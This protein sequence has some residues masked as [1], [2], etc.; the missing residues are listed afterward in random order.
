[1][2]RRSTP[3]IGVAFATLLSLLYAVP[4]LA[5]PLDKSKHILLLHSYHY[6]TPW[7]H[8]VKKGVQQIL[9]PAVDKSE[10][11]LRFSTKY[12]DTMH[13]P[14]SKYP[15]RL[16]R[17]LRG[18]DS[19]A[20]PDVIITAD[21]TALEILLEHHSE[22]A[23]DSQIVF[24]GYSDLT[25]KGADE[26]Q[27]ITGVV[28]PP[29][30]RETLE[31]ILTLL[32][33]TRKIL[34]I[35]D[36]SEMGETL[37]RH[38]R[39]QTKDLP[40][41]GMI[42]EY[43][44]YTF[45]M[46]DEKLK[47]LPEHTIVLLLSSVQ[48]C[49]N[50]MR[51]HS[52]ALRRIQAATSRPIFSILKFY[53]DK[54]IVGGKVMEGTAQGIMAAEVALRLAE[55][56]QTAVDIPVIT[57][58]ENRFVFD[59]KQLAQ[60]HISLKKVPKGSTILHTPPSFLARNKVVIFSILGTLA[61][62]L[63]T[64]YRESRH[65]LKR[66]AVENSLTSAENRYRE[67]MDSTH[68]IILHIDLAGT[69]KFIND[70]G[71]S[72]FGY[73]RHELVGLNIHSTIMPPA[74][75]LL[76]TTITVPN[77]YTLTEKEYIRKNKERVWVS[78]RNKPMRDEKG[79]IIGLLAVGQDTTARKAAQ[80]AL[81]HRERSYSVLL[82]SLPG[83][84]FRRATDPPGTI[85]FASEG[86]FGLTGYNVDTLMS[87]SKGYW[88]I[89]HPDDLT[90]VQ[91]AISTSPQRYAV[92]YRII[93]SDGTIRWVWES[94]TMLQDMVEPQEHLSDNRTV[95]EG[96]ISDITER[97]TIL[98]ELER[99][100][101]ELEERVKSR[102]AA[103]EKSLDTL[104]KTQGKLVEK[105]KMAALGCLVAGVAHEINTPIGI[106]VTT[107]SFLREQLEK[108]KEKYNTGSIRR[109]ELESFLKSTDESTTA[110]Y[111]NLKRAAELV[112]SFKRVAVDQTEETARTFN[113][114]EYFEEVLISLGPRYKRTTH[115]VTLEGDKN[116]TI[117]SYPGVLMHILTNIL[118]NAM[119]HGFMGIERGIFSITVEKQ[120]ENVILT[121]S[122]N[123]VGMPPEVCN[124]IF[125]PFFSTQR[126]NG[127]TGLGL[128]IVYNL[129]TQRLGGTVQCQS[130]P[131]QGTTFT[132][133]IPV[134][135]ETGQTHAALPPR[136]T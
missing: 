100:N 130:A 12:L 36:H 8:E 128:H 43:S 33:E 82:S 17:L 118:T 69:I 10:D 93:L 80:E 70:Y 98:G 37:L 131:N 78:W 40:F 51:L 34:A 56:N 86:A 6:D 41:A 122:D 47:Y 16:F 58:A 84:A 13:Y 9:L 111:M 59:Y 114:I 123:G 67:L 107:I 55:K 27:N 19:G 18:Q 116:L 77:G 72:F 7:V 3:Q 52:Q 76:G 135:G 136:S 105:E 48:D 53:S 112:G 110:A 71:L 63:L 106:G 49:D 126:G 29:S 24:C 64:L 28:S 50:A 121:M 60:Y 14:P 35:S 95:T 39:T 61:F 4:I 101:M 26:Y 31:S 117:N 108:V 20:P 97:V 115:N 104:Q 87:G 46:L 94:G 134:D 132:I 44:R 73:E 42:E 92:E 5:A 96:F 125:E 119:F 38:L 83:M 109:S 11:K 74:K 88:S 66:Q 102:T 85:L 65:N 68:S 127:G 103:L 79:N 99:L 124:R 15:A 22:F 45:A 2:Q 113:I 129:I 30:I 62:L 32:P 57:S 90:S 1:M 75:G 133:I 54:G 81:A 120:D 89:V 91:Q 23:P 21:D 25:P